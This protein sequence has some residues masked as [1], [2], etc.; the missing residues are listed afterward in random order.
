MAQ[1]L[2]CMADNKIWTPEIIDDNRP[3]Y[4]QIVDAM[5]ND[6]ASGKLAIGTKLP[7]QRQLAWHL[8]INLSTVT[9]AFQQATKQHL[10]AGEVGRGTF[11][12]GQSAEAELFALQQSS[13][14]NIIDLST[15][16]PV[17]HPEDNDLEETMAAI[18][19]KHGGLASFLDFHSPAALTKLKIMGAEW[20]GQL[21]MP[22]NPQQCV[23]TN[24]AQNALMVVLLACINKD[25]VLMVNELTFPGMKALAKQMGLKLHGVKVDEQGIIPEALDLAVRTTGSKV[26]VSDPDFQNP[27]AVNMDQNRRKGIIEVVKRHRLL[28]IEEY[29]IGALSDTPP[30]SASLAKNAI[31]ISSFTKAIAPGIRFAVI[32]GEHPLI[33]AVQK[34]TQATSW[35]LSPLMAE[36]AATWIENGTA[37][38]RRNWQIKEIHKRFRLFKRLFPAHQ[39]SGNPSPCSHVWLAVNEN[40]EEIAKKLEQC[41]VKVV[42]SIM[43][44]VSHHPPDFIRIS[45]TAAKSIQQLKL[46]LEIILNSGF[47]KRA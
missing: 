31:I 17:S 33:K 35:Q 19:Q 21:G 13:S 38:R 6:I 42:P 46:G 44:A 39:Y 30:I 37:K 11:V 10:I 9:K 43:F 28:F 3:M 22:L 2:Y 45:L 5:A 4:L 15:H 26:L 32:G 36:V 40:A 1:D 41:G 14:G 47:V 24:T 8:G 25:D 20:L 7:P 27:T 34:E 12:L 18:S 23:V 16:V 29:V